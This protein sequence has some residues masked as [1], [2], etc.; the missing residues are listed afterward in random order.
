VVNKTLHI[1]YAPKSNA[2]DFCSDPPEPVVC[3][4][5]VRILKHS[6]CKFT[7]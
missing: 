3:V 1:R 2:T 7:P 4:R 6:H 5:L